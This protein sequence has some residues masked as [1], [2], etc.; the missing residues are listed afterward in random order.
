MP[1]LRVL[2]PSLDVQPRSSGSTAASQT[3]HFGGKHISSSFVW[4]WDTVDATN[5]DSVKF[6]F[7]YIGLESGREISLK[8]RLSQ[9]EDL[10]GF[11]DKAPL[12]PKGALDVRKC[13]EGSPHGGMRVPGVCS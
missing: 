11:I 2:H 4:S 12:H 10:S 7:D 8:S 1:R 5:K 9:L 6:P 3:I 13:D